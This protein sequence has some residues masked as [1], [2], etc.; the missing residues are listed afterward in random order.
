MKN[1]DKNIEISERNNIVA[2]KWEK[3]SRSKKAEYEQL[4]KQEREKYKQDLLFVRQFL[5]MGED[6]EV[7]KSE[8]DFD[9]FVMEKRINIYSK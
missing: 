1:I 8:T 3:L 2:K 7:R 4:S 6:G 9:L 5:F